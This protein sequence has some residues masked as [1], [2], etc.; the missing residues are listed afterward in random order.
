[1]RCP[2]IDGIHTLT[3]AAF[4]NATHPDHTK[5]LI[6]KALR[7]S[8]ALKVSLVAEESGEIVAHVALSPVTDHSTG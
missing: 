8:E 3:I 5:Q 6:A 7:D 1:M 4:L 2:S